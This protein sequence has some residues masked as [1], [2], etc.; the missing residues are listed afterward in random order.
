MEISEEELEKLVEKKVEERLKQREKETQDSSNKEKDGKIGRRQFLKM[1]GL[2][3]G[4]IG[5]SSATSALTFSPLGGGGGS[6]QT[7]SGV[8]SEGNDV[9]GKNIVDGGTTIWNTN[10]Q[11]VP[12][13]SLQADTND[14]GLIEEFDESA[15]KDGGSK[16]IGVQEF[17]GSAGTDGQILYSDGSK[18]YWNTPT[19]PPDV[20]AEQDDLSDITRYDD[21]PANQYDARTVVDI[22]GSG[23]L[24]SG[25]IEGVRTY[26]DGTYIDIT[27]DGNTTRFTPT[28]G[29]IAEIGHE[30]IFPPIS[31]DS[32]LNIYYEPG[33]NDGSASVWVKQ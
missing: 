32:S 24:I 22:S 5:L 4:A 29:G 6:T 27:V 16:E 30:F 17:S 21:Y 3:A 8:L 23:T 15:I 25:F 11:Y 12:T 31:F 13:T 9:K 10:N 2:G 18:A 20:T 14:D 33:G 28:E 7:L 1:A 26:N 19:F